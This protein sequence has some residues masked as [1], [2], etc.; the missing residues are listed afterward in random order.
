M[1]NRWSRTA[2]L[3]GL[4]LAAGL[5]ASAFLAGCTPPPPASPEVQALEHQFQTG[6]RPVDSQGYEHQLEYCSKGDG[7][8][9][10]RM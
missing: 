2:A 4:A 6:C 9:G 1:I 10:G 8:G 5:A 3:P 7:G